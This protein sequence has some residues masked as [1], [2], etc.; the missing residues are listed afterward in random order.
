MDRADIEQILCA[1][2]ELREELNRCARR[3]LEA[4][5]MPAPM[6]LSTWMERNFYLSEESSYEKG[7]WTFYPFQV[8]IADSIGHDG[9]EAVTWRKSARTGYTKIFLGA[10]CY[11][12]EHKRR[13]QAVYQ[14]TDEDRDDFTTTELEPALRDIKAMRRVFP[15]IHKKSKDNTMKKKRFIGCVLHLRGARAAKNFRRL[16][17]DNVYYDETDGFDR[18]VEK[19]GSPFRLGD[20]RIE[21]A[22][23]PKSVAGSTP[24]LK[25]FSLI[26]DRE[27]E[28]NERFRYFIRCPHCSE[29][30]TLDWGGKDVKHGF[31]WANG[32]PT[33]AAH[34]CPH[35]GVWVTQAEYLNAWHG[36]W[37]S[38]SGIWIDEADAATIRF[39]EENGHEVPPPRHVAFFTWTAYSPQAAW[40]T[41]AAEYMAAAKKARAGDDSDLKTFINTTRGETFE[42]ELEKTDARQLE[43][44][45]EKYALR[46][47]PRGAVL[48]TGG[49]DVQGDRWE[50][51]VW[52]WGRGEE[53]WVIDYMVIHGNP[54]DEGEWETKLLP[55][56]ETAFA[57]ASG[58]SIRLSATAIDTG[59]HF[60]HQAYGFVRRHARQKFF[61]VKGDSSDGR[62]VKGRS[63]LQDVNFRGKIVKRGIRLWMVG[64]DTAKDLLHGRLKVTQDGP[65]RV[66]FSEELGADFYKQLTAESRIPVKTKLGELYR[67]IKPSG[68]RNE[69]L[70]CTVYAVFAAHALDMHRYTDRMWSRLEAAFEA[71][72]FDRPL[73]VALPLT[74]QES[75]AAD[76]DVAPPPAA[77]RP[78]RGRFANTKEW[79]RM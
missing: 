8:A 21:G 45:A 20:K 65:G 9:I 27:A 56:L 71:D 77:K 50:I 78:Q 1:N 25:G 63:G 64:T 54:A 48:L 58:L 79:G 42:I 68:S 62:P 22:T 34:V 15:K 24:K 32:D 2:P 49:V 74:T 67:W 66:H 31:K 52:G 43:Q 3:G 40:V 12:A 23:F 30:H 46:V 29:E 39:R 76:I 38:D 57:H 13:N 75:A 16:T 61:A 26:E 53:S 44:R 11:F 10:I 72:L 5:R 59:G 4:L 47:A 37:K 7:A 51:V 41:I 33:T 70:D 55:Y 17:V 19:E 35:C 18:D 36:R 69:V 14:P 6:R 60:T 73:E 28:A